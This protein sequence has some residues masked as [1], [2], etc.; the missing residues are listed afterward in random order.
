MF[1]LCVCGLVPIMCCFVELLMFP[2]KFKTSP[3]CIDFCLICLCVHVS[4]VCWARAESGPCHFMLER[5][6][7]VPETGRCV[8]FLFGGCGGNRNNF[9]SEEYC[10]AVCSSSCKSRDW[11][12]SL[13]C[14][15]QKPDSCP[16]GAADC[17]CGSFVLCVPH[18][19]DC[20]RLL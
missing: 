7:F 6:Y 19:P 17:F 12:R 18:C 14:P 2:I 11:S 4:A 16:Q 15:H 13:K 10:L 20:L 9:G 8:P 3:F 1:F 5:W